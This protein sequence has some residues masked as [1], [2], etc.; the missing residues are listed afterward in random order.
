VAY[1][2]ALPDYSQEGRRIVKEHG[3]AFSPE[4]VKAIMEGKKFQTR[5]IK[6]RTI[7]V[8]DRVWVKEA[9]RK[10]GN[11]WTV[12][13]LDCAYVKNKIF[14]EAH[15]LEG[16][17]VYFWKWINSGL[18]ARYMPKW[19]AGVKIERLQDITNEDAIAE[20]TH[21]APVGFWNPALSQV[22]YSMYWDTLHTKKGERWQDN[23]IVQVISFKKIER[24]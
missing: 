19:A 5:R 17:E 16:H 7:E 12:Y 20:G 1:A 11:I 2:F 8:G 21:Y 4:M 15:Q 23:P 6:P 3:I 10:Q 14:D 22:S 24:T 9:L 13:A 18:P